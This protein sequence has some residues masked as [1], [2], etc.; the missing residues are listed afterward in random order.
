MGKTGLEE[1]ES[2]GLVAYAK[3]NELKNK[4]SGTSSQ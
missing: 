2:K 4:N 3:Q 1:C